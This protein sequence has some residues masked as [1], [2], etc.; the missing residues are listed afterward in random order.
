MSSYRESRRLTTDKFC[1]P[2]VYRDA[3]IFN[4]HQ[5]N[6]SIQ[7]ERRSVGN[8]QFSSEW[9]WNGVTTRYIHMALAQD[10]FFCLCHIIQDIFSFEY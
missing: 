4:A 2:A 5:Q 8:I 9:N 1:F 6:N 3:F 10:L 7:F